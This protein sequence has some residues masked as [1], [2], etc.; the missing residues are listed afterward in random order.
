MRA[1]VTTGWVLSL[2]G[3]AVFALAGISKL[4]GNPMESQT[5]VQYG[6]PLWF[7]YAIGIIEIVGVVMLLVTRL[8]FVGAAFLTAVG[9]GACVEMAMHGQAAFCWFPLVCAALTITGARLRSVM[10]ER[11]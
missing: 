10:L 11:S 3:A 1:R 7:M 5:F 2:V 4:I 6:L 9:I 8:R